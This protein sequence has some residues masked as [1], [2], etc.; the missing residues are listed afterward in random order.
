VRKLSN[1]E[2]ETSSS[3]MC[4]TLPQPSP[5]LSFVKCVEPSTRRFNGIRKSVFSTWPLFR[6]EQT[7]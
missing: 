1:E 3:V 2:T 5:S 4:K 7:H 6:Q